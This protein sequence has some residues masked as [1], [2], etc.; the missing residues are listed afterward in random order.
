MNAKGIPVNTVAKEWMSDP[1]FRAAYDTLE[2]EFS[3][4]S[5]LIRARARAGLTQEE[6][7]RRMGTTQAVIA[8]LEGGKVRPSTRTLERFAQATGTRLR[9]AF[10]EERPVGAG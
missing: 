6:V 7:A 10:E 1:E 9:I 5:V 2:E 8:R 4:V 3:L